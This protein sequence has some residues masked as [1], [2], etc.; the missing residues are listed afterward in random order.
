MNAPQYRRKGGLGLHSD[1]FVNTR[2]IRGFF[3]VTAG[4]FGKSKYGSFCNWSRSR[5]LQDV[6]KSFGVK[7]AVY[8]TQ[9]L[10]KLVPSAF[11]SSNC[12]IFRGRDIFVTC[13]F[14]PFSPYFSVV[15]ERTIDQGSPS[16]S[17]SLITLQNFLFYIF[18]DPFFSFSRLLFP[19]T[20]FSF[21]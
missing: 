21:L 11:C 1:M 18:L 6:N 13:R 16:I 4:F 12:Y 14:F 15:A 7:T 8:K 5:S 20:F 19:F 10:G 17:D 3:P 2:Y 9:C